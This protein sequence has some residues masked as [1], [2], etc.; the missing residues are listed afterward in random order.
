MCFQI[1][2]KLRL[3]NM[4]FP[5]PQFVS[6]RKIHYAQ[7]VGRVLISRKNTL[8]TFFAQYLI[9]FIGSN[10]GKTRKFPDFCPIFF[11][12]QIGHTVSRRYA[13]GRSATARTSRGQKNRL[14][15]GKSWVRTRVWTQF[16]ASWLTRVLK[17]LD[18]R[19]RSPRSISWNLEA[20]SSIFTRRLWCVQIPW[21]ASIQ[22]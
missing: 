4:M 10:N 6:R 19:Q 17:C 2:L 12:G 16:E 21:V 22:M 18:S 3:T 9:F 20:S 15:G 13:A 14:F 11:C 7:N 1:I 8:L 5:N